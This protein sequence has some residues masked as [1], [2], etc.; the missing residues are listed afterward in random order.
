MRDERTAPS[1]IR[2]VLL[3]AVAFMV[4]FS[5]GAWARTA[6][7]RRDDSAAEAL[8]AAYSHVAEFSEIVVAF[9]DGVVT[10]SGTT[11]TPQAK[12]DAASIAREL[13]GVLYVD[14]SQL[15]S[16][17]VV[18]SRDEQLESELTSIYSQSAELDGVEVSVAAGVVSL[19]GRVLSAARAEEAAKIARSVEG[20][21]YVNEEIEVEDGVLERV[22]P[23]LDRLTAQVRSLLARAPLLLVAGLVFVAFLFLARWVQRMGGLWER[24]FRSRIAGDIAGQL[25][26]ALVILLGAFVVLELLDATR[27]AAAALGTAGLVGLAISFAFRDIIENWLAS[28]LL[29]MRK[30]FRTMDV[31]K[32]GEYT[33]KVVRLTTSETL[34]MTFDGNHVRLPNAMVF[35]NALLNYSR[36]PRRRFDFAVG[37][38]VMEDLD[39]A[40]D[41]GLET[42]RELQ[43]VAEDPEPFALI[44]ELGDSSVNMRFYGWVD[45]RHA[46]FSKVESA[47]IQG[48][49][50]A[51]DRHGV[52][53]PAPTYR[54]NLDRGKDAVR[55][56][57]P[58]AGSGRVRADVS[59]DTSIDRQIAQEA[60]Q[61]AAE[62][63]GEKD[64]LAEGPTDDS[65]TSEQA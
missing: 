60:A 62:E 8:R 31:V 44:E 28:I 23:S 65:R 26:R 43:G 29:G 48:V 16:E 25:A 17:T 39:R 35:K 57:P 54:V 32:I 9:A 10:L 27:I 11:P 3:L 12:E 45:Q 41:L 50:I 33:G 5:P 34:L 18:G 64:F 37:V 36:N 46:D 24:M 55:P 61:E 22:L 4:A 6:D 63:S 40:R 49:K 51:F 21:V 47:A 52:D 53:M 1:R 42:L 20:T 30:P 58:P 19:S 56:S 15:V 59:V 14:D 38:G 2:E 7:V 13:P